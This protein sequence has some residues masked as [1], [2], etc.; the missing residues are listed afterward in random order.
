MRLPAV[1]IDTWN[2]PATHQERVKKVVSESCGGQSRNK[3]FQTMLWYALT[4]FRFNEIEVILRTKGTPCILS[5]NGEA[6]T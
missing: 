2:A 1:F 5:L 6:D 4:K 3:T